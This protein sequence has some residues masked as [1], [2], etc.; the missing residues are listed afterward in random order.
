VPVYPACLCILA[1]IDIDSA[2]YTTTTIPLP[3]VRVLRHY[4]FVPRGGC[5]RATFECGTRARSISL[6]RLAKRSTKDFGGSIWPP[7]HER[8]RIHAAASPSVTGVLD[9]A[10]ARESQYSGA[11]AFA[12]T[13]ARAALKV[14]KI[15]LH[16]RTGKT[17]ACTGTRKI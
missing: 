12:I 10:Q 15:P 14:M 8:M 7:S 4:C 5:F 2:P 3:W 6:Y 17:A 13:P 11:V 16:G 9:Y 1:I